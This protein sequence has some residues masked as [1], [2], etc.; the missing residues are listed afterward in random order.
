LKIQL[1]QTTIS[2]NARNA[3]PIAG[4]SPNRRLKR[5]GWS[6]LAGVIAG[7]ENAIAPRPVKAGG[8]DFL[9]GWVDISGDKGLSIDGT[10]ISD[11]IGFSDD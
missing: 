10:L 1:T 6:G 3:Y 8:N 4:I 2:H 7:L 11:G 5:R 9:V